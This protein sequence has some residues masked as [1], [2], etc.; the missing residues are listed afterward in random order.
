MALEWTRRLIFVVSSTQSPNF[1][2]KK[3]TNFRVDSTGISEEAAPIF[4][5]SITTTVGVGMGV[6]R[7]SASNPNK[8]ESLL[9]YRLPRAYL[10]QVNRLQIHLATMSRTVACCGLG[11][12]GES[13]DHF[14]VSNVK[15]VEFRSL[16]SYDY[17]TDNP[18]TAVTNRTAKMTNSSICHR[19][20][21]RNP[22]VSRLLPGS[23]G[24]RDLVLQAK[25]T[26]RAL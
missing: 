8:M 7:C 9:S 25:I 10:L 16:E 19:L 1:S 13:P 2:M 24:R 11:K 5:D 4:I 15:V 6:A 21:S 3:K 14:L 26:R 20:P 22:R 18:K 12:K 17:G 23:V